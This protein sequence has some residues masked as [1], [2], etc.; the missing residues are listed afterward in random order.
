M[1]EFVKAYLEMLSQLKPVVI[2]EFR[3]Y[4][5]VD[6]G[7]VLSYAMEDL[8][9]TYIVVDTETFHRNRYDWLVKEGKLV[10][11]IPAVG[12]LCPSEDGT[13]CFS[14]DITIVSSLGSNTIYWKQHT[15]EN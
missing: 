11:P 8:P 4:Y 10:P 5:D 9:G 13:P 15:Y 7:K 14:D 3:V 6:T 2:P 1:D 12:K